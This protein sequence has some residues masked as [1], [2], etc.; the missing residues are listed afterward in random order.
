MK[1]VDMPNP[2]ILGVEG[3]D[4]VITFATFPLAEA[5][6]AHADMESRR[7]TGKLILIP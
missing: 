3:A 7:T 4:R 1:A 2:K 6:S 5:A